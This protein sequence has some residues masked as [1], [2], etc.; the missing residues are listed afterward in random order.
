MRKSG[1]SG[2]EAR[3]RLRLM[4]VRECREDDLSGFWE[5]IGAIGPD[6][7]HEELGVRKAEYKDWEKRAPHSIPQC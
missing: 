4:F 1:S 7:A 3:K 5:H 6:R 2:R